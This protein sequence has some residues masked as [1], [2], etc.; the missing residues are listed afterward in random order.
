MGLTSNIKQQT[1]MVRTTPPGGVLRD[2]TSSISAFLRSLRHL[3]ARSIK[4]GARGIGDGGEKE[5]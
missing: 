1:L 3:T 4:R 2:F 5:L